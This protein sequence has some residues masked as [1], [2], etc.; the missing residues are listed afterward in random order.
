[1]RRHFVIR[2]AYHKPIG[3]QPLQ[4]LREH[5]F[6]H[7]IHLPAQIAETAGLLQQHHQHENTPSAGDMLEHFPRWAVR[8]QQLTATQQIRQRHAVASQPTFESMDTYLSVRT[9]EK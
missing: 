1:M 7:A 3:R 4:R 9:Y 8:L 2:S 6:A 5:L